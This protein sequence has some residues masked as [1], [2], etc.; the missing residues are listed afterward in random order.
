MEDFA[1]KTII[2]L[3]P[4]ILLIFSGCLDDAQTCD[5]QNNLICDAGSHL[6]DGEC[7][8]I[9]CKDEKF[10]FTQET[11]CSNDGSLEFCIPNSDATELITELQ[12]ISADITCF[13]GTGRAQCTEE[14]QLCFFPTGEDLCDDLYG[15][16][17]YD[18]WDLICRISEI[19]IIDE[20]VPTFYE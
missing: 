15:A 3:I 17:N 18:G 14:E 11:G 13:A 7:V 8:M 19:E 20:I 4:V 9:D 6:V 10:T 5:C 16:L 1:M 2:L 12:V